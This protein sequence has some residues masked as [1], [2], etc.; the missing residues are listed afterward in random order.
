MALVYRVL[1]QSNPAATTPTDLYTVPAATSAVTSTLVVCNQAA[2]AAT[3]RV[4]VRVA[5]LAGTAK[6]YLYYDVSVAAN[7]TLTAT[8][9]LTLA[10]TDV[11]TVYASSTTVSFCLFGSEIT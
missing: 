2:G 5:G 7:A 9:G 10:A 3:F 11:V 4:A 1:G 8:L 6:Q